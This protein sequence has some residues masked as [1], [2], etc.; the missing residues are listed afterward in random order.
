VLRYP[1][2]HMAFRVNDVGHVFREEKP[3]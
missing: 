1:C 2:W 3:R